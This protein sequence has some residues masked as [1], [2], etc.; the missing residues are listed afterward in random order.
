MQSLAWNKNM[1][2]W[3]KKRIPWM[4]MFYLI[5]PILEQS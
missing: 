1:R 2:D 3:L 5:P 4:G